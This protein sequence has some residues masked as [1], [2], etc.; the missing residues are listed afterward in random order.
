MDSNGNLGGHYFEIDDVK[1]DNFLQFFLEICNRRTT[2]KKQ[3]LDWLYAKRLKTYHFG[4]FYKPYKHYS[5]DRH[6]SIHCL[7][8]ICKPLCVRLAAPL[9]AN[10]ACF[11]DTVPLMPINGHN[12]AMVSA[13]DS[14]NSCRAAHTLH[15]YTHVDKG[16]KPTLPIS[17]MSVP[18]QYGKAF[19]FTDRQLTDMGW[20]CSFEWKSRMHIYDR[21][22]LRALTTLLY[23]QALVRSC[24]T[25]C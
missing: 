12:M 2:N 21:Y 13:V 23:L 22:W 6:H 9:T 8:N 18:D 16:D 19:L 24:Y 4:T 11:Y 20:Y 25:W 17:A 5:S 1:C 10:T 3:Q 15:V 14:V 7:A